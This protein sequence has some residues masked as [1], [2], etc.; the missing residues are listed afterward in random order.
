MMTPNNLSLRSQ[1]EQRDQTLAARGWPL[2][3]LQEYDP[4]ARGGDRASFIG[5]SGR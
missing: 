3:P 5:P 4:G 1:T 2:D